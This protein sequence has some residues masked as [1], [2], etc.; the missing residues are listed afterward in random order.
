MVG[1]EEERQLDA[2]SEGMIGSL[3]LTLS[4]IG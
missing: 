1:S 3:T 2:S 4:L